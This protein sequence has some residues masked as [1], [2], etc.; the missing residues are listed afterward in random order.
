[1]KQTK[2][3][4]NYRLPCAGWHIVT[5]REAYKVDLM[6]KDSQ[7]S[8]YA[9][10]VYTVGTLYAR[11]SAARLSHSLP[12]WRWLSQMRAVTLRKR[13]G[14]LTAQYVSSL[15]RKRPVMEQRLRAA[16]A[17]VDPLLF[18]AA[19]RLFLRCIRRFVC[20][21]SGDATGQY[22]TLS[23]FSLAA[24]NSVR[25]GVDGNFIIQ[26]R[27]CAFFYRTSDNALSLSHC[28]IIAP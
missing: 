20:C 28:G 10:G 3:Q 14:R 19:A 25:Y 1:M 16:M 12:N 6:R 26:L 11:N 7:G 9:C 22:Y 17:V 2:W 27:A 21:F 8:A 13:L 23:G 5:I 15:S 4:L 24:S 18:T